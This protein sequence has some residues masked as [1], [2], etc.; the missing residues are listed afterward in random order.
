M[1][2]QTISWFVVAA[3]SLLGP[4]LAV[5]QHMPEH[6]KTNPGFDQLKTLAGEWEGT[7]AEGK[8]VRVT[9]EVA[10][11]GSALME[12]LH[13]T[14]ESEMVTM[15]SSDG[16]HLAMTHYCNSGNQPQ[17][18]TEP[19]SGTS[20]KFTFEFVR[21]TNLESP[22]AGHMGKL[23]LTLQDHDHFTEEWTWFDGGKPAHTEVFHF[24]RKS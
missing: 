12:R 13:P 15:Y 1:K 21:A 5:P 24:N 17:M 23:V 6:V 19:V 16:D 8:T 3:L 22:N 2:K 14:A 4:L 9:Y 10:S 18:R 11:N 20:Q 7:N